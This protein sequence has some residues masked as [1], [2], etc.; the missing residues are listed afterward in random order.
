[1]INSAGNTYLCVINYESAPYLRGTLYESGLVPQTVSAVIL[2]VSQLQ[3][4]ILRNDADFAQN[5]LLLELVII[6]I[7]TTK[8]CVSDSRL[9]LLC[10]FCKRRRDSVC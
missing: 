8:V 10:R 9:C 2:F 7:K 5:A 6:I 3:Y 1:M 4:F